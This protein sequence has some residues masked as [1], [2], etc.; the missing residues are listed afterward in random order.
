[1][2]LSCSDLSRQVA[3]DLAGTAARTD[4][5]LLI[6]YTS[7]WEAR[8]FEDSQLPEAIQKHLT[9]S[10][11]AIPNARIVFI[12]KRRSGT[13][14]GRRIYLSTFN[15]MSP[16]LLAWDIH[17]YEDLL[18][19]DLRTTTLSVPGSIQSETTHLFLI[20]TNG[21]RDA[22]CARYGPGVFQAFEQAAGENAWQSSHL[23]GHRFA[24][25]VIHL[26]SGAC[27]GRLEPGEAAAVVQAH[28][29]GQVYL[30]KYRGRVGM[31]DF[32]QAAEVL[33]RRRDRQSSLAALTFQSGQL[34]APQHWRVR[35]LLPE[36]NS[37]DC[38]VY[39]HPGQEIF[40]SC[41]AEA[42]VPVL[43]YQLEEV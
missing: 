7:A 15:S 2:Q 25:S 40:Q 29:A 33:L 37:L 31:P 12:K 32:A 24:P 19:L 16:R 5:Y 36:G 35:W 22:C 38:Q 14:A 34:I 4:L 13:E 1:M 18:A 9:L 39:A 27:Y 20:C 8:A 10:V 43:H 23:G 30:E 21:R 17:D 3:E 28:C 42:A 11:K 41:Q 6:E 26:P